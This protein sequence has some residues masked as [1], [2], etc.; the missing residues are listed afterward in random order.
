MMRV[1][2]VAT[3]LAA[4]ALTKTDGASAETEVAAPSPQPDRAV[5]GFT[6]KQTMPL[7]K[8]VS[9]APMAARSQPMAPVQVKPKVEPMPEPEPEV[10][11]EEYEE[12][13]VAVRATAPRMP[14]PEDFPPIAQKQIAAQQNRI[15]HIAEH[16]ARKKKSIFERLANV[17]L[18]RKDDPVPAPKEPSMSVQAQRAPAPQPQRQAPA[19]TPPVS[20]VDPG[21]DD[22]QLEIPAFLRRQAN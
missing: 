19:P 16:A 1:S 8:P 10:E 15:E 3:G 18:G 12:A 6:G 17:G 2:V 20:H 22:D 7:K 11:M 5:F 13:P 9:P 14:A 21:L 4:D